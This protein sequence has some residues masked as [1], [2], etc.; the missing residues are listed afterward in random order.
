MPIF[1]LLGKVNFQLRLCPLGQRRERKS[2]YS[3]VVTTCND[4]FSRLRF[5]I[6]NL[7]LALKTRVVMYVDLA[8]GIDLS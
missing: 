2:V 3:F 4:Y 8:T 6:L 5:L 7:H 1:A